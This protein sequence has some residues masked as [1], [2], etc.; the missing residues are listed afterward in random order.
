MGVRYNI[1]G[2]KKNIKLPENE[3]RVDWIQAIFQVKIS[4]SLRIFVADG[5]DRCKPYKDLL[6]IFFKHWFKNKTNNLMKLIV[7]KVEVSNE[8]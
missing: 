4:F 3:Q 6:E 7:E 5:N 2:R 8:R 1:L